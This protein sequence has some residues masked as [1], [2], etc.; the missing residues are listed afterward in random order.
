MTPQGPTVSGGSKSNKQPNKKRSPVQKTGAAFVDALGAAAVEKLKIK[1]GLNTETKY[2]DYEGAL[3]TTNTLQVA[4]HC[5]LTPIPQGLTDNTH[6]G[7]SVRVTKST[8]RFLLQNPSTNTGS[9]VSTRVLL[10][11]WRPTAGPNV[12]ANTGDVLEKAGTTGIPETLSME[13]FDPVYQRKIVYDKTFDFG[14]VTAGG[15]P[16]VFTREI[17]LN[18]DDFHM[19]WT[20]TDT[21]G[22]S[23]NSVGDFWTFLVQT[24]TSTAGQ[25]PTI[26]WDQRVEFVDN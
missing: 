18:D 6:E 16:S 13:T 25:Y 7:S 19:R 10:V 5:M 23:A 20:S 15:C 22:I 12:S 11:R 14:L 21:A 9:A 3:N 2:V 1:L 26:W 24:S 17:I 8:I 4:S